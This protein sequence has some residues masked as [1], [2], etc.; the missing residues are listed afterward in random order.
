MTEKIR[1]DNVHKAF[2]EKQVLKGVDLGIY[3]GETL[4]IIGKSGS[5]K[6]VVLKHLI[7]LLDPDVG[8]IF[9]DGEKSS[10]AKPMDRYRIRSKLGV[11]FQGAALF[12]SMDIYDN[13]AF[14][15]R[16]R[17]IPEEQVFAAV[18]QMT[19]SLA[20][21][22]FEHKMP[23]ELSGG[24]QKRAG[25]ARSLVMRPEIMLYDE[26]TTGVDPVTAAAVDAMIIEMKKLT[27]LTSVVITHDMRSAYKIADR[28]AMLFDGKII[29]TGSP[30]E[31][32]STEDPL[33]RQFIEGRAHGPIQ[34]I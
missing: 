25:L 23:S 9:I 10:N 31:L 32:Q 18:S 33:L 1:F 27:G 22:G 5:G 21:S 20:L 13:I 3:E 34:V 19:A 26:P 6:S 8:D 28:I 30:S 12:D 4:C 16:R 17:Q 29:F 7:G 2:G 14:G 11:L 24:M 15:L